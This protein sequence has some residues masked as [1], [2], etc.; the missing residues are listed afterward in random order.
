MIRSTTCPIARACLPA[1]LA[2]T[3]SIAQAQPAEPPAEPAAP[4]ASV[5]PN[6]EPAPTPPPDAPPPIVA[7]VVTESV[8]LSPKEAEA[9]AVAEPPP[10]KELD[11]RKSP[12]SM[13][14]WLRLGGT[15]QNFKKPKHMDRFSGDGE[16]DLLLNGQIINMVGI[17]ANLVANFGNVT[18]TG[19]IT[20]DVN[21]MDLIAKFDFDDAFHFWAGRMLVPSDRTNFSGPWFIAPWHYPTFFKPFAPPLG[22]RQGPN[23]RNDGA[24]VWG[25][26]AGGLFKYYAGIYDLW[27]PESRPLLSGRISLSL[28][29]PEPGYYGSSTFYGKDILGL[30]LGAQFQKSPIP[31]ATDYGLINADILFEKV[32]GGSGVIDIEGAIYKY[33]GDVNE[34]TYFALISYLTPMKIGPGALQPLIRLQQNK[35]VDGDNWTLVDAQLGYV[36]DTYACRF[37]IGYQYQNVD[38]VKGNQLFGGIQLQK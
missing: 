16:L 21:V 2:L 37:A 8:A 25:Q 5:V 6:P 33:F 28:L 19:T 13:N 22:P 32:L 1:L 34:Y 35:P 31:G 9:A 17:T 10:P 7:P 15:G 18:P 24:T 14:A 36:V 3:A 4:P 23:G 29:N 26:V 20:G 38:G 27:S 30:G 11:A 12:M